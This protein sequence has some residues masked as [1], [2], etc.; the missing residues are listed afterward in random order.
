MLR[1]VQN[2]GAILREH[3]SQGIGIDRSS[4]DFSFQ[5]C[6]ILARKWFRVE[7]VTKPDH[8]GHEL[9]LQTVELLIENPARTDGFVH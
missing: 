3:A 1:L 4:P 7:S 9:P 8:I 5:L 2:R 6:A